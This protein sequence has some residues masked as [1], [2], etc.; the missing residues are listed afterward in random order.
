MM[1]WSWANACQESLQ[2]SPWWIWYTPEETTA[3]GEPTMEQKK[4]VNFFKF[5]VANVEQVLVL[6]WF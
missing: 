4:K 3:H 6:D 5:S 1:D 2:M